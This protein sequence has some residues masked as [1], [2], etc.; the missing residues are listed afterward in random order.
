MHGFQTLPSMMVDTFTVARGLLYDPSSSFSL[1]L[2]HVCNVQRAV[3]CALM[4]ITRDADS[5]DMIPS[6]RSKVGISSVLIFFSSCTALVVVD[7]D[8][9]E[10]DPSLNNRPRSPEGD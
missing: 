4:I 1:S 3:S 10:S 2:E 7:Q 6:A 9:G 8:R 5:D